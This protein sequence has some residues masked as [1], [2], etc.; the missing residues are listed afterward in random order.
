MKGVR[1]GRRWARNAQP[2]QFLESLLW[3]YGAAERPRAIPAGTPDFER[4]VRHAL[5]ALPPYRPPGQNLSEGY[6]AL[7][8]SRVASRRRRRALIL[9]K[10]AAS[11]WS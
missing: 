7:R 3:A 8:R 6:P 4:G 2:L 10:P 11:F 1:F 5:R 9:M